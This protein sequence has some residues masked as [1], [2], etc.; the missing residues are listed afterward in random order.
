MATSDCIIIPLTRGYSTI[1]DQTDSDLA[2]FKWYT[3]I[4]KRTQYA[5]RRENGKTIFM[6]RV[7]LSRKLGRDLLAHELVDHEKHNGLDNRR[8][9]LRLASYADNSRNRSTYKNKYKG[10]QKNGKGFRAKICVNRK[11]ICLGT[12]PT[13][14]LAARAYNEAAIKY[15]GEFASL[16]EDV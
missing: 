4:D 6:H 14:E 12:F 10:V 3:V 9:K 16:N 8:D 7:I 13:I 5:V 1:I 11:H 2:N 15:H